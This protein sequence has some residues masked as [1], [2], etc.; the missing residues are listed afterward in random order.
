MLLVGFKRGGLGCSSA[1]LYTTVSN[2]QWEGS[3]NYTPSSW[4]G[5]SLAWQPPAY[6]LGIGPK[7]AVAA[8]WAG[9]LVFERNSI[10]N[11]NIGLYLKGCDNVRV[12]SNVIRANHAIISEDSADSTF[13]AN[14]LYPF[15][16]GFILR[17]WSGD[18]LLLRNVVTGMP[19]LDPASE[20]ANRRRQCS[21][22]SLTGSAMILKGCQAHVAC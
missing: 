21:G 2:L 20:G 18:S 6:P 22:T 3:A 11:I 16:W 1:P 7:A 12:E 4:G 19:L 9:Y 8:S 17:G 14:D 5:Q 10:T 13:V 15:G